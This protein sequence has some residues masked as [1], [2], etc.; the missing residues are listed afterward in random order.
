MP[1]LFRSHAPLCIAH[2]GAR[3]LAP[4]NTL[5]A[6]AMAARYNAQAWECDVRLCADGHLV[7]MHD[8]TLARTTDVERRPDFAGRRPWR[9]SDFT[10]AELRQL[11]AGSWFL[12]QD[13]FGQISE[14][15]VPT[16]FLDSCPGERIPTLRQALECSKG[17]GLGIN[18]EIKDIDED[19]GGDKGALLVEPCLELLRETGMLDAA[20]ISSFNPDYLRR[21]RAA[22]PEVLLGL[23]VETVPR[24]VA[25]LLRDLGVQALHPCV[26]RL[27]PGV[28][29][30]IR[31]AGFLVNVWT[32]NDLTAMRDYA[33]AGVSGLITDWPQ[34]C[35]ASGDLS[36][37]INRSA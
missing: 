18:V 13:P 33:A 7:L 16:D 22:C 5:A 2:R 15:A 24:N 34:R 28:V 30:G 3:S 19:S 17:L 9:V 23:V 25:R 11:D 4:E 6:A 32:V 36:A 37:L 27:E 20:L 12:E 31:E 21:A 29:R 10:L 14:G 1:N 35:P 26:Q 8:Q